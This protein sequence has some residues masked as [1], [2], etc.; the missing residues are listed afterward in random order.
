M[1]QPLYPRY[2]LGKERER[3]PENYNGKKIE[4]KI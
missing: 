1:P 3:K 2:T 4:R